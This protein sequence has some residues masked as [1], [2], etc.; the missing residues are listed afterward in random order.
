[1]P[2][3]IELHAGAATV[4]VDPFGGGTLVS[5]NVAGHEFLT[6]PVDVDGP[7]PR[8]GSFVMA[9]WVGHLS[10]GRLTFR[11]R[12]E[13]L[14]PNLGPH[15]V[16]GLVARG[17]W[18]IEHAT[19]DE[20]TLR[21]R[22]VDPWPFGG[23]VRQ[24]IALGPNGLELIAEVRAEARPMPA[25][26]GWHPWFRRPAGPI[27]A[28]LRATTRLEHDAEVIPTGRTLPADGDTDLRAGPDL[29]AR[30]I[31]E[32]YIDATS[33]AEL[34]VPGWDLRI[35]FDSSI[36]TIVVYTPA[37]AVCVEPWSAWP[38][39]NRL[40]AAGLPTGLVSLEPGETLRRRTLW[41]WHP[42]EVTAEPGTSDRAAR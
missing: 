35:H 8:S 1:L 28:R 15:A 31:D 20:L 30:R 42:N 26:L 16:H 2:E 29:G 34:C 21:R 4:A 17:P 10:K 22:L 33:P 24:R 36:A 6:P 39:A 25:A 12:T 40:A 14:P 9:P 38:D 11:G 3:L 23:V 19:D 32:V 41:E 37:E 27:R 7:F 13:R 5:I 18:E